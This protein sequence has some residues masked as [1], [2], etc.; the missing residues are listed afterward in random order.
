MKLPPWRTLD[1]IDV[2]DLFD[3]WLPRTVKAIERGAEALVTIAAEL[4]AARAER[5][6]DAARRD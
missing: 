5:V 4:Q 2:S 6:Q 1:A 3:V